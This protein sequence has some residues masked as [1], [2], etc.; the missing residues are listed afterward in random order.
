MNQDRQTKEGCIPMLLRD[1]PLPVHAQIRKLSAA[2]GISMRALLLEL[3]RR[4]YQ[5]A[6]E[7]GEV[8]GD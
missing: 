7:K 1:V 8:T 6:L 3:A 2:R 4:E 5:I